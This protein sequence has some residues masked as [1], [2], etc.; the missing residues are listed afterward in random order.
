MEIL[1]FALPASTVR[2]SNT[3]T[4]SPLAVKIMP[5]ADAA[6]SFD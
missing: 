4:M 2:E 5:L 3:M 1:D 6:L